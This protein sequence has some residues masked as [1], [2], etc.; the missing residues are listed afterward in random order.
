MI[1]VVVSPHLDDGVFSLGATMSALAR[2]GVEVRQVTLFA[3]DPCDDGPASFHDQLRGVA[4]SAEATA[5]R[6][7]ED[8]R[9]CKVL[10]IQPVW[11]DNLDAAYLVARDPVVIWES[12]QRH[13]RD[14][15]LVFLPGY[16]LTHFDHSYTARL[17][18][19]ELRSTW[20]ALYAEIPYVTYPKFLVRGAFSGRKAQPLGGFRREVGN[21]VNLRPNKVDWARKRSAVHCYPGELASLGRLGKAAALYDWAARREAIAP[22][23]GSRLPVQLEELRLCHRRFV[24]DKDRAPAPQ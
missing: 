2:S 12:L 18:L 23:G 13:L 4:T 9:A 7:A 11:C 16:P 8:E 1:A 5:L 3:G 21:W 17:V 14:A 6:R 22:V 24:R 19:R 15:D 10:G 20:L